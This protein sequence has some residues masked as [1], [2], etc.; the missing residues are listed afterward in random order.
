MISVAIIEDLDSYRNAMQALLNGSPGF[1]CS[2]AFDTAENALK[3]LSAISIDVALVDIHLPGMNGIELVKCIRELLPDTL[4]MMCTAYDE[5]EEV[6]Q[7]LQAGAHGYILKSTPPAKLLEAIQDLK[8]GG[9]PMSNE[10]ARKVVMT[11]QQSS[12]PK[13][14][15]DLTKREKEVLELLSHGLLYKEIAARLFI[16]MD[17]VRRHCFNTY[18]KLHV[19]NKTEAI[20]KYFGKQQR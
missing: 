14:D 9:S 1:E 2:G 18:T 8:N 17:T 16:S 5:D 20:N 10:I 7:A 12:L 6:F 15:F 11:F 3:N 19:K 13:P 4:C